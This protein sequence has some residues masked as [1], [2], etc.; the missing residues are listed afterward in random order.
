MQIKCP[1]CQTAIEVATSGQYTCGQCRAIFK[2]DLG[3][4]PPPAP[5][6]SAPAATP[7]A[8]QAGSAAPSAPTA[9]PA[10]VAAPGV[11]QITQPPPGAR[12]AK[13]PE[14]DAASVCT[15][16]GGFSCA[17]CT[18]PLAQG[19]HCPACAE[20]AR[21]HGRATPWD[22]RKE[23]G[24]Y[25]AAK[26]TV[27]RVLFQPAEFFRDMP[28]EGGYE[29]PITFYMLM[30]LVQLVVSLTMIW[31]GGLVGLVAA[32]GAGVRGEELGLVIGQ[33]MGQS[34]MQVC[35]TPIS[36]IMNAFIGAGII[37]VCLMIVGGA[38]NG[39]EATVRVIC[40]GGAAQFLMLAII[41]LGIVGGALGGAIAFGAGA[42]EAGLVVGGLVIGVGM[43]AVM[44]RT[45]A[46][47]VIGFR[48][49]HETTTGRALAALLL[50]LVVVGC[51]VGG[52]AITIAGAAAR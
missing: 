25:P 23:L 40:Y 22:R 15:R 48:E 1:Y 14:S 31:G 18:V 29:N 41:P 10:P 45:Y 24:W 28:R 51:C 13:H 20:R 4:Q 26:E 16:C 34:L 42:M 39:F 33:L 3:D 49:A 35:M 8:A 9:A 5:A 52:L 46:I 11:P 6:A 50:P 37:H 44:I 7:P 2:V 21:A 27:R 47:Q 32:G 19:P 38:K 17:L 12:C 30:T 36:A 43:I